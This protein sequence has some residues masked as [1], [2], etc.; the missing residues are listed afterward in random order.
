[1]ATTFEAVRW[2][3]DG[4][5]DTLLENPT[6]YIFS[7]GNGINEAGAVVGESCTNFFCRAVRSDRQ[8]FP[9]VL[10]SWRSDL[11]TALLYPSIAQGRSL[12]RS[13][14]AV[15]PCCTGRPVGSPPGAPRPEGLGTDLMIS[16]LGGHQRC[17]RHDRIRLWCTLQGNPLGC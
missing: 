9:T 16:R 5:P 6:D 14:M 10:P 17:R 15:V 12:D 7:L 2:A 13:T 3:V 11:R 1:M 4:G 8:G